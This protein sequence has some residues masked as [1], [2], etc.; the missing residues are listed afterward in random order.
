MD[1]LVDTFLPTT[2]WMELEEPNRI[3]TIQDVLVSLDLEFQMLVISAPDNGQVV[4]KTNDIL[5]PHRRGL[6]LMSLE[7]NLKERIDT[8][9]TLWLEPVGDKSKLR[10]LRGVTL[11]H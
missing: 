7:K 8:G 2:E 3:Q 9:I 4:L 11:K 5:P 6:F 1:Y 10:Q